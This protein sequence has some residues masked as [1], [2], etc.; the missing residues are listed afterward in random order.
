M[1]APDKNRLFNPCAAQ[2]ERRRSPVALQ[3]DKEAGGSMKNY[4][5][6]FQHYRGAWFGHVPDLP[7]ILV[8]AE[9][10]ECAET[11]LQEAVEIFLEECAS[12]GASAPLRETDDLAVGLVGAR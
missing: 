11:R 9:T 4:L 8:S 7:G 10:R 12:D 3:S 1:E 6:I 2:P 5:A